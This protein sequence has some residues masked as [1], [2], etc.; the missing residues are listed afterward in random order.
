MMRSRRA[1]GN[2]LALVAFIDAYLTIL[3]LL[4]QGQMCYNRKV[5]TCA[6]PIIPLWELLTGG[7]WAMPA[8]PV[9][10]CVC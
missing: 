4:L 5:A 9:A 6:A 1:Q 10:E 3:G 2:G 7:A 8:I